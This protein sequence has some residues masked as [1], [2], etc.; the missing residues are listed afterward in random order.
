MRVPDN[1]TLALATHGI[2]IRRL[3]EGGPGG[4]EDEEIGV[5]RARVG[6]MGCSVLACWQRQKT[7]PQARTSLF[8]PRP[9]NKAWRAQLMTWWDH[10]RLRYVPMRCSVALH[11]RVPGIKA[12]NWLVKCTH[13]GCDKTPELAADRLWVHCHLYRTTRS[14][15]HKHNP[16]GTH[17][18]FE[19]SPTTAAAAT[20]V[21]RT[22]PM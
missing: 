11:A 9:L 7:A 13:R 5:R 12:A 17:R 14:Q 16:T 21:T 4:R 1:E 2:R 20:T 3:F 15:S 6:A 22:G 8:R 19:K 10:R 18:N